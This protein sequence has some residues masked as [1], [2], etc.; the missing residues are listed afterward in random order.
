[1][2]IKNI[3]KITIIILL[4]FLVTGALA[5]DSF[6]KEPDGERGFF[7]EWIT[8]PKSPSRS[9][10][11]EDGSDNK[12][13]QQK[14][15]AAK[16]EY[17]K[18]TLSLGGQTPTF[19][20]MGGGGAGFIALGAQW[21]PLKHIGLGLWVGVPPVSPHVNVH[22]NNDNPGSYEYFQEYFTVADNDGDPYKFYMLGYGDFSLFC[23][24]LESFYFLSDRGLKGLYGGL[25]AEDR[26]V[27]YVD[28]GRGY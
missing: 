5:A 22:G 19:G 1:M 7:G 15:N 26:M 9:G 10:I 13:P 24:E 8:P 2:S 14:E 28:I 17:Y 6:F 3:Y 18:W 4:F 12:S 23:F 27:Y 20:P 11:E 16:E 25:E 21:S